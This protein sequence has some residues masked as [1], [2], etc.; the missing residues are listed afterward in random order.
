MWTLWI[1]FYFHARD[2][3]RISRSRYFRFH[4][5]FAL[6]QHRM[7]ASVKWSFDDN[8][9]IGFQLTA[10][11]KKSENAFIWKH[12]QYLPYR[13]TPDDVKTFS[14]SINGRVAFPFVCMEWVGKGDCF[15]DTWRILLRL[16]V[17]Q[18][19]P[20]FIALA[21]I[22]F[23]GR[24]KVTRTQSE[25]GRKNKRKI[26]NSSRVMLRGKRCKLDDVV[27]PLEG[28]FCEFGSNFCLRL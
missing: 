1:R 26:V 25:K 7:C 4:S 21:L 23:W 19:D 20:L 24:R 22:A 6:S 8:E 9:L 14:C 27:S 12:L 10:Q 15:N 2:G 18:A 28:S 3:K 17:S 5:D 13:L 11:W 16:V